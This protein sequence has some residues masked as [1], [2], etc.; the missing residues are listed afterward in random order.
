MGSSSDRIRAIFDMVADLEQP[1]REPT[2][3]RACGDDEALFEAVQTLLRAMDDAGDFMRPLGRPPEDAEGAPPPTGEA[4]GDVIDRYRLLEVI[5]EGGFGTVYLAE[6][7][8]P[9]RRRVALKIVKLGMDSDQVLARFEQERQALARMDHPNIARVLD[10]GTTEGGRPYFAMELVRGVPITQ[11]CD[12]ARLETKERLRLFTGVCK[13]IHH[14][15]Q[16]GIIHRDVKP[17][18][19]LVTLQD[20]EPVAKVIDFGVAKA[21]DRTLTERTLYTEFRQVIGTPAYMSPEQAGLAVGDID[22]RADVYSLG[23]LLYELLTGHTPFDVPTLLRRGYDEMLRVIR[24]EEPFKPS[25]RVSSLGGDLEVVAAARRITPRMLARA[26]SGDLDWIVMRAMDKDRRRRYDSAAALAADVGRHLLDEPVEARA[27]TLGY[28]ARKFVRR[29]RT[30]VGAAAAVLVALLAGLALAVAGRG[31][32]ERKAAAARKAARLADARRIVAER[33]AAAED[34]RRAEAEEARAAADVVTS[35]VTDVLDTPPDGTRRPAAWPARDLF[36]GLEARLEPGIGAPAAEATLYRVIASHHEAVGDLA[37]AAQAAERAIA[38]LGRVGNHE[39]RLHTLVKRAT[40]SVELGRH[41]EAE[42]ILAKVRAADPPPTAWTRAFANT[43]EANVRAAR[44]DEAG[45]LALAREAVALAREHAGA[46]DPRALYFV[47]HLATRLR[48]AG[49]L[50]ESLERFDEVLSSEGYRT[51]H[52]HAHANTLLDSAKVLD[53][54]RRPEAAYERAEQARAAGERLDGP[55]SILA[56]QAR[57]ELTMILGELRRPDEAIMQGRAALAVMERSF[58]PDSAAAAHAHHALIQP[59]T[60]AARYEDAEAACRAFLRIHGPEAPPAVRASGFMNLMQLRIAQR[61]YAEAVTAG[62]EAVRLERRI[63]PPSAMLPEV[64]GQLAIA[65]YESGRVDDALRAMDEVIDLLRAQKVAKDAR[66]VTLA[67]NKVSF[68]T[69]AGRHDEA[70]RVLDELEPLLDAY[71]V[72]DELRSR[73][74]TFRGLVAVSRNRLDEAIGHW[75]RAV[76]LAVAAPA[77][78][79]SGPYSHLAHHLAAAGRHREAATWLNAWLEGTPSDM[80]LEQLGVLMRLAMLYRTTGDAKQMEKYARQGVELARAK[81]LSTEAPALDCQA[82]LT[83]SLYAQRRIDEARREFERLVALQ[84]SPMQ[85]LRWIEVSDVASYTGDPKQALAVHDQIEAAIADGVFIH[86][87]ALIRFSIDYANGLANAGRF[88][89]AERVCQR[90]IAVGAK[91][92]QPQPGAEV[93][94]GM[95]L[96]SQDRAREALAPLRSSLAEREKRFPPGAWPIASVRSL[97][98]EA[99]LATE[100]PAEAEPVLR[101]AWSSFEALAKQG[102]V[103]PS[104]RTRLAGALARAYEGLGKADEAATFQKIAETK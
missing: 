60:N 88:A 87:A 65:L 20:G 3:R 11:Y 18:N 15:H 98:G 56:A 35:L 96:L 47:G 75:K 46:D 89:D 14:A 68:L 45:A 72:G 5:G 69:G 31:E 28:R 59:L 52:P 63:E 32:A 58:G 83:E 53:L 33:E 27:P 104:R 97:L 71:E 81:G 61:R 57:L 50:Q 93:V 26:L 34:A 22:T 24:E 67:H 43:V 90:A 100:G 6:Q 41:A 92:E 99:L 30:A 21:T 13:A 8:E 49:R 101:K 64:L 66:V 1:E 102:G 51:S 39:D 10:G 19:V 37:A 17:S 44:G 2:L 25:T 12:A 103:S 9:V 42:E 84:R 48:L 23:V 77:G 95:A 94:L 54:L 80:P 91:R 40:Y 86:D 4:P 73:Q 38:A 7:S 55:G 70:A 16:K 29:H 36:A 82:G 74:A 62:I 79:R 85:L 78:E 76:E